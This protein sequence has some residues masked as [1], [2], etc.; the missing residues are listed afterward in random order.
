MAW[1][2]IVWLAAL[3]ADEGAV[4]PGKSAD[5]VMGAL[6]AALQEATPV[7]VM[8]AADGVGEWWRWVCQMV[9]VGCGGDAI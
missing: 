5:I 3:F 7:V 2:A 6:A 1:V 9:C 4:V 8:A